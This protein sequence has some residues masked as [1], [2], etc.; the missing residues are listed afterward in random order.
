MAVSKTQE[1]NSMELRKKRKKE[2]KHIY[3]FKGQGHEIRMA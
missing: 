2:G 1:Y 3:S